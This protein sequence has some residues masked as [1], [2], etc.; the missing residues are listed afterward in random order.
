[1]TSASRAGSRTLLMQ[2]RSPGWPAWGHAVHLAGQCVMAY[3]LRLRVSRVAFNHASGGTIG[4]QRASAPYVALC[5]G[6]FDRALVEADALVALAGGAARWLFNPQALAAAHLAADDRL[7]DSFLSATPDGKFVVPQWREYLRQRALAMLSTSETQAVIARLAGRFVDRVKIK[8]DDVY[9]EIDDSLADVRPRLA[10]EDHHRNPVQPFI[11]PR[12]KT[13]RH[14]V[15]KFGMF[16]FDRNVRE[17]GIADRVASKLYYA[18]ISTI[19]ELVMRSKRDLSVIDGLGR[20]AI[21][22]ITR[23]LAEWAYVLAPSSPLPD[24]AAPPWFSAAYIYRRESGEE[25]YQPSHD[26][27]FCRV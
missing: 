1:M 12:G 24:P 4:W 6:P 26:P 22:D 13:V 7:A 21:G 2:E 15:A 25:I 23:R 18:G 5:N 11:D 3:R 8:S 17:L 20:A 19:G 14:Y 10:V 9:A 16:V 27:R